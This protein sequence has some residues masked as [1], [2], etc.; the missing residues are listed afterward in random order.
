MRIGL[1][2]DEVLSRFVLGL[3]EYYNSTYKTSLK[4]EDF[5]SYKFWEVWG[6][7]KEDTIKKISQVQNQGVAHKFGLKINCRQHWK[8][9]FFYPIN[10]KK[11]R[12]IE[13]RIIIGKTAEKFIQEKEANKW[14]PVF[15][16]FM[17]LVS[18]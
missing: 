16:V 5:H 15:Q 4:L 14:Q 1:D 17:K 13:W 8:Q 11:S 7:T 9:R 6:G 2:L 3:V 18:P 12:F 10:P